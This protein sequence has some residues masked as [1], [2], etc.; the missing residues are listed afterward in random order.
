MPTFAVQNRSES[1][2]SGTFSRKA[3]PVFTVDMATPEESP[4]IQRKTNCA[5]GGDCPRCQG[6]LRLQA[7][8]KIGAPND[9]YEQEADRMADQVMGMP[10]PAIQTKPG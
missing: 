5:C 2:A 3:P 8:L 1:K 7:K 6:N 10:E 4:T 9:Q